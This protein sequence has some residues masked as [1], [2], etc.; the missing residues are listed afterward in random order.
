[1]NE[2]VI[3]TISSEMNTYLNNFQM[4]KLY[5]VLYK[6]IE[7]KDESFD[8]N[9]CMKKFYD[10][11]RLEGCSQITLTNYKYY[12]DMF[13][14]EVDKDLRIVTTDDIRKFLSDH[15]EKTHC[16]NATIDNIRRIIL[17]FFNFLE[18]EEYIVK[19]PVKKIHQIRKEQLIK[20]TYSDEMIEK[21]R[22]NCNNIR[23]LSIIDL[24]YS[25]GIRVGELVKIKISDVN[26]DNQSCIVFGKGKKMREVYFDAKTKMHLKEY[27][28]SRKD[29]NDYL[30]VSKYQPYNRLGIRGVELLLHRL[31][32]ELEINKVYPHK[33]RRTLATK[34]IDKGMPIEQVQ[35]LLGHS[36][37]DT[38][39]HYA[40][41]NQSNVKISHRKYIC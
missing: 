22:M 8:N 27:L 23:D 19:N 38:T 18:L 36:K 26:F 11:K 24:L 35:R 32:N 14:N 1:M 9:V 20:E 2:N 7:L 3:R 28:D 25:S 37:I 39:M 29:S 15:Q 6:N 41:V 13:I 16:N 31:G 34:A 10:S 40:M 33:F 21:L 4:K 12:L 30:F 5:S 17:C